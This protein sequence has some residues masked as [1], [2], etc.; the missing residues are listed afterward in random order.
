MRVHSKSRKEARDR[1]DKVIDAAEASVPR[2]QTRQRLSDYLD[3]WLEPVVKP[4]LRA[5]TYAGYDTMVRQHIK[6]ALGRKYLDALTPIDV[7]HIV[8]ELRT[9]RTD[10]PGGGQRVLS[11]R[12]VQF[13]HAVLRNVA[14]LVRV[15]TPHYEGRSG[16]RPSHSADPPRV[17]P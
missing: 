4:E 10:G 1:L 5:S 7:R 17:H 9:K 15:A 16:S 3:Y 8:T 2:P 14:K 6:P 11:P 12:M 13:A